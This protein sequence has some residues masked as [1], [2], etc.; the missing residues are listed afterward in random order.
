[1]KSTEEGSIKKKSIIITTHKYF[2]TTSV[3]YIV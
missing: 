1:M 3:E 2:L